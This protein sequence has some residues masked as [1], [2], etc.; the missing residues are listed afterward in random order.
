M[1]PERNRTASSTSADRQSTAAKKKAQGYLLVT[2]SQQG[3]CEEVLTLHK[4][5]VYSN[6]AEY[7]ELRSRVIGHGCTVVYEDDELRS[8]S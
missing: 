6:D 3:H 7:E 8:F 2:V 5:I 1:P 4:V